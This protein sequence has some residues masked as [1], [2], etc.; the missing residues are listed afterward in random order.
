MHELIEFIILVKKNLGN[1]FLLFQQFCKRIPI[2]K[3][4]KLQ[5]LNVIKHM[6]TI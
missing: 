6:I 1:I 2:D 4:A 3:T 5:F